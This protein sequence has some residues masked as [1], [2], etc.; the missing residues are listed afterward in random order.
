MKRPR[1]SRRVR[2]PRRGGRGIRRQGKR[3]KEKE[4]KRG[5]KGRRGRKEQARRVSGR[6]RGRGRRV[7]S[8]YD[9]SVSGYQREEKY[10]GRRPRGGKR[11]RGRDGIAR[12]FVRLTTRRTPRSRRAS[13]EGI[14]KKEGE[15]YG[16]FVRREGRVRAVFVV[17]DVR[18]F[19]VAFEAVLIPMYRRI[20]V[21]GTRERKV[22]AGYRFFRYTMGGSVRMLV[23]VRYRRQRYGT[24][25]MERRK[26]RRK[27]VEEETGRRRWRG[28]FRAMAVKVPMVPVHIWLP[29]AHVEAPTGGSVM[30][31]GILLKR[32]TYGMRRRLRGRRTEASIYYTPRVYAR[33]VV[34]RVYPARTARRQTDRKRIVAYASVSHMNMTLV[35]RFSMT[36]PG[37]EGAVRQMV[38]HGLVAGGRFMAIG[39]RY[40]RY[41]TR[42]VMYYGGVA[43][44]MPRY[45]RVRR[46]L[47]R[48][49]IGLPGTSGFVG[50]WRILIGIVKT[51]RRVTRRSRRGMVLGAAYSLWRYNRVAYG[52][53]KRRYRGVGT[54][55]MKDLDRR[56]G[57]MFVPVIRGMVRLG[58][59]PGRVLDVIH[60]SC[61]GRV[62][63]RRM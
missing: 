34:G 15:Y 25:D 12:C 52:N 53:L 38:S 1:L 27:E 10:E 37:V 36:V 40:D 28:F 60:V 23:G 19:Y 43:Q 17:T 63:N 47:T 41:H 39:V 42:R 2:R 46:R 33:A 55:E 44:T 7:W 14:Q 61:V 8:R 20:G 9:E 45:A 4:E 3:R 26:R 29:E 62:E 16:G 50:E 49:N 58:R 11:T 35:G 21:W 57:R 13:R 5:R 32:G 24:T 6:T 59:K 31:A 51:N 54:E 30:L 18:W 56:E 22:R 48:G